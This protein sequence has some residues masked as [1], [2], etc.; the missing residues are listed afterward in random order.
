[1]GEGVD[2]QIILTPNRKTV[3]GFGLGKLSP[4]EYLKQ[5]GKTT[6]LVYPSFYF[7]RQL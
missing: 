1:V 4:G 3:I 6:G 5:A 7:T 2:A